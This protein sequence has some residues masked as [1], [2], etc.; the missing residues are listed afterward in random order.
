MIKLGVYQ[1]YKGNRYRVLGIGKHS[2]T[3]E[4]L[5]IY[6]PLYDNAQTKFW[7]RPV[8]M[9]GEVV[10]KDGESVP[11]FKYLDDN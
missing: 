8:S 9:F 3:L 11:R 1:H 10:T 2:E 4:D 7:A 5:V 6:E